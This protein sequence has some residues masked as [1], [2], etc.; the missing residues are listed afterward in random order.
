[1]APAPPAALAGLE[2]LAT[3][4]DP[5]G[6]APP[7]EAADLVLG[8]GLGP[9]LRAGWMLPQA[10][11]AAAAPG[12]ALLL[13]EPLPGPL[14]DLGCGQDPAWWQVPGGALP[15]AE[16]WTGALAAAGWT[17]TEALPLL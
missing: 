14:F 12:A 3:E 10:L 5:L 16:A 4:W 13:A 8:L 6:T 9:R 15:G 17:G 1:P 11:R 7:P 2:F